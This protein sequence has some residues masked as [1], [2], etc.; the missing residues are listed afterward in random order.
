MKLK[1]VLAAAFALIGLAILSPEPASADGTRK[2]HV[3][4][5][6]HH[7]KHRV[8]YPRY[9]H[10]YKVDPYAWRYS[11]RGYYPYYGSHYWAPAKYVK[12]R[13]REHLRH[14]NTQPPRFRY[15]QSWGYPKRWHH[16]K[17]HARNHG[18]HHR[19]HW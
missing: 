11:P 14:W 16:H 12:W 9:V 2:P 3:G 17:W 1:S 10:H 5:K 13:N 15:Y 6:T 8:Y 4:V 18:F 19:W 7:I